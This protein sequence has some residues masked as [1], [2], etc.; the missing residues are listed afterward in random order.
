MGGIE[1]HLADHNGWHQSTVFSLTLFP[2]LVFL[3]VCL[4]LVAMV[5]PIWMVFTEICC[6]EYVH[7]GNTHPG[8]SL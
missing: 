8:P 7:Q 3:L 1:D 2:I 5:N 4:L 6:A